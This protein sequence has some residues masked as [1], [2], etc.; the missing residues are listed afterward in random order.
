MTA[1]RPACPA[2]T[3]AYTVAMPHATC[4][5]TATEAAPRLPAAPAG[6]G[7]GRRAA[8]PSPTGTA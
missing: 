2:A 8:A 7:A 3:F 4:H 1:W 6:S 5:A